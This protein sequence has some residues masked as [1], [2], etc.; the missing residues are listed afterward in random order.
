METP[1]ANSLKPALTRRP[2]FQFSLRNLLI[3]I[4]VVGLGLGW[5]V[6][7]RKKSQAAWASL[8][9]LWIGPPTAHDLIGSRSS[10][11]EKLLGIDLPDTAAITI[12]NTSLGEPFSSPLEV[13]RSLNGL[14]FICHISGPDAFTDQLPVFSPISSMYQMQ[15]LHCSDI[16]DETVQTLSRLKVLGILNLSHSSIS[17]EALVHLRAMHSLFDLDLSH[18]EINGSGFKY[19]ADNK[20]LRKVNL[21]DTGATWQSVANLR[22]LRPDIV[23]VGP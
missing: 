10:R 22:A 23:I 8:N 4:L 1:S 6:D 7:R 21:L 2:W 3:V 15:F 5:F 19:L 13:G 11:F 14:Y 9:A 12:D 16:T 18:T 17:D 20:S